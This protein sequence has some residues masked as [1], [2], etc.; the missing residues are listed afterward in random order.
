M[1]KK[2]N[3]IS[4]LLLQAPW[5]VSVVTA[6]TVYIVMGVIIPAIETDN[7]FTNMI[8]NAVAVPAPIFSFFFLLLAPFAFFNT[9]RKAKLLD[10]QTN[11]NSIRQLHWK[12]FEELV[13]EAYRRL[14]YQVTEGELGPDG[15]IDIELRK[16]G[17]LLL[18]QCKQW[19]AR[20]VGVSIIREMYG[21]LTASNANEI[22]IICSGR[23]TQEAYSFALDKPMTLMDGY[24]LSALIQDVQSSPA[25]SNEKQALCP[26]CRNA[27]VERVAKRGP[28]SG[29]AFL[30]CSSFPKCRYT[31]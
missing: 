27:L 12:N 21:V 11:L 19:K 24:K 3:S 10:Q 29:N 2:S 1:S 23:F 28:N 9:R 22:I 31:E 7:Q 25:L 8:L 30:G 17:E 18:V 14:G 6:A 4:D 13:A 15:G 20:K 16:D 5:W 26:R